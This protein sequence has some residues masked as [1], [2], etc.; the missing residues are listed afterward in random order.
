MR[1]VLDVSMDGFDDAAGKELGRILRYWAGS[2]DTM[3][4][5]PGTEMAVY[6]SEHREVGK[7][8]IVD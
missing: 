6:D 8:T 3:E 4:L 2:V 7:W 1:F 5:A